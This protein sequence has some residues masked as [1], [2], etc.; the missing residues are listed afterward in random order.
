M[1]RHGAANTIPGA[2]PG[3]SMIAP[4]LYL[5]W[6]LSVTLADLLSQAAW[7]TKLWGLN[8]EVGTPGLV[9]AW[10]LFGWLAWVSWQREVD[11]AFIWTILRVAMAFV[12]AEALLQWLRGLPEPTGI[13]SDPDQLGA[14]AAIGCFLVVIGI[15]NR[16]MAVMLACG[17]VLTVMASGRRGALIALCCGLATLLPRRWF[18]ILS[19]T[20][21]VALGMVWLAH[22]NTGSDAARWSL[23]WRALDGIA[24]KPWGWGHGGWV[25]AEILSAPGTSAQITRPCRWINAISAFCVPD[26]PLLTTWVANDRAHVI[27]LDWAIMGGV[28]G[29]L[30]LAALLGLSLWRARHDQPLFAAMVAWTVAMAMLFPTWAMDALFVVLCTAPV[31]TAKPVRRPNLKPATVLPDGEVWRGGW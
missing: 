4:L 25:W 14:F 27:C 12:C 8:P 5:G 15:E 28:F 3:C 1:N 31:R 6:C 16:W 23:L 18:W 2:K 26:S 19:P 10:L 11:W 30:C 9:E 20:F 24:Q 7:Q 13:F 22:G 17:V 29:A 21:A